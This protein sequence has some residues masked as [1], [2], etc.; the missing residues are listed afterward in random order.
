MRFKNMKMSC[1]TK[2]LWLMGF[3]FFISLFFFLMNKPSKEG[4]ENPSSLMGWSAT[5]G[6]NEAN[7]SHSVTPFEGETFQHAR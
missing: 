3:L 1:L 5:K 4:M 6:N 7:A 2:G